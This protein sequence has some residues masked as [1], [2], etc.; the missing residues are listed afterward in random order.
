MTTK[1]T[2]EGKNETAD[3]EYKVMCDDVYKPIDDEMLW[4]V[5]VDDQPEPDPE[6]NYFDEHQP[7]ILQEE[8]DNER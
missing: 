7:V 8:N 1:S 4:G 6:R 5:P 3:G 2:I